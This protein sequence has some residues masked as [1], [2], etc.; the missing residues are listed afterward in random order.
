MKAK[1]AIVTVSGKAYYLLVNELKRKNAPFLS[2][3]PKDKIPID[4]KVVITTKKE[5]SNI[6]SEN[7][8]EYEEGRNPSEIVDEALRIIKGKKTYETLVIGVDPGQNFGIAVLGDWV[9]LETKDCTSLTET[10][11][12]IKDVLNRTPSSQ[13]TIRIGNGAPT[14]AKELWN[15][16]NKILPLNTTIES[17]R[18]EG[19][20]RPF[21]EASHRR[22]KRD[23]TSALRIAQRQGIPIPRG[24][25]NDIHC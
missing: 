21:G 16:L 20:S 13:T 4:V 15:T 18:E 1:I 12:T 19:T 10:I 24:K 11:N 17:V 9:I 22:G 8:L 3:T 23:I 6:I 25:N 14:Y 5:R 7:I 2:L